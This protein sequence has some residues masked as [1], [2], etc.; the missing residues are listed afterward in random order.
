[1]NIMEDFLAGTDNAKRDGDNKN[2]LEK[3]QLRVDKINS[4]EPDIEELGDEELLAKTNEFRSR[5]K[6]G[7][8]INGKIL[9]EAFAV[10]REAAW[11]VLEQR[12]YDVQIL[13]GLI[14]HDGR[15][16]EMATGEGK[17]LVSTLPCYINALTGKSAFVITVN[18]YLAKRDKEKMGQVHRF[19]G[20]S[21]GLIQAGMDEDQRRKAYSCDVVYVTNSELGF[22]Y[23]RDHLAL[24]PA[25]IVLPRKSISDENSGEFDG[26]CV[27]DEADSVLIDE[28]RTPLIISKQVPAPAS[29]YKVANTLAAALK[30]KVHYDID[31]KNKNVVLNER[32]YRDS[33]NALGIKSLFE[34]SSEHTDAWAPYVFNAV[35][36]K[37]LFK[38]DVEYSVIE[39]NGEKVGIGI[40]DAFTGRVLDGRRW[41]DGLHQSIEAME[42][43]EVSQQ[44]K[45]IAKV[46]YQALFRQFSRLSGMTGTAMA[47]ATEL[48]LTY[49]IKVTPVPTALPIARRDYPDVAFKTRKAADDALIKEIIAVGGGQ[50]DGRPCLIGTT[51]VAQSESIVS[52]L[53]ENKIKAELL[54]ASPENAARESEIIA[55][56]GRSGIVTV[57]TNMAGRGT[58]I[59]LGGCPATMARIKSRSFLIEKGVI[60]KDE[61]GKLPPSPEESYYPCKLNDDVKFMLADAASSLIKA[62]GSDMSSIK[63]DEIL[64]IATDTTE[65]EDDPDYIV[66]LRDAVEAVKEIYKFVL[67]EE[68]EV[69]KNNG[70][71]YVMGTN[72]HESS[73]IDG[74]LRGRA[75]RQGDPGTSRFFLSFEDDMF[76]IFGGDSLTNILKTFRVSDDMPVEAPQV[77]K[78]LDKVQLAVEEKYREIREQILNFDDVLND[79]RRSIYKLRQR[80]LFDSLEQTLE[81]MK[82]YNKKTIIDLV[83]GHVSE[84]R[85]SVDAEKIIKK[86]ELFFPPV[87]PLINFE[88]LEGLD[89]EANINF[90][91]VAVDE[92]FLSKIEEFDQNAKASGKP[93]MSLAR[94]ANYI[95]L[96]TLD[97]AWSDH[98]Q[99]MEN[100]KETVILKKYQNLDPVAEYR[101]G[102]F[103]LFQN[104]INRMRLDAT[105][106]LWQSLGPV[107]VS[108]TA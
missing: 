35:K 20:L 84:D 31:E 94:S 50:E 105:Y 86:L 59:L 48:E 21:V 98:L 2:Y 80:I 13:G 61:A 89:K 26:F 93:A 53:A 15:L 92:I 18:D 73:R 100:L 5:L 10:V 103:I 14:L 106:S 44:S 79:Q 36:A 51:S 37:E 66:K 88:D 39:E 29:R 1:M 6:D 4:L 91:S 107:K 42:G 23:L 46:T 76:V 28:A 74:Q 97:N 16:A 32:G 104:L 47:D 8:D 63:L 27:V 83:N 65:A 45:V 9:E 30:N 43:I 95:M 71:L 70:G 11:R 99:S 68:K 54:N 49:G 60:M 17:T 12:H 69:V 40:I 67:D 81:T 55:Q 78:A 58:D 57:A 25:Q 85:T 90:I 19:L 77:S 87:A 24:S 102:A 41:S 64:T 108:Q 82:E 72:R 33:E 38:K 75:G 62:I 34:V 7:E 52:S 101:E 56:A 96:V 22:D 3:L